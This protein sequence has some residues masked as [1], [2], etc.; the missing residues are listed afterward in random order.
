[1]SEQ[2]PEPVAEDAPLEPVVTPGD[3]GVDAGPQDDYDEGDEHGV[4]V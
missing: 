1:M 2:I 3:S 4:P